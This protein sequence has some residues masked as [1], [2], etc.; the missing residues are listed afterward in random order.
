MTTIIVL[1]FIAL[2]LVW[3]LLTITVF[4]FGISRFIE[5]EWVMGIV[6]CILS[7]ICLIITI[8]LAMFIFTALI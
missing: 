4:V 8:A 2:A 5:W 3:A 7:I 6:F 1:L